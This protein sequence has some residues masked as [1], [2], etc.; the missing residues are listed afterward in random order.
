MCLTNDE[1]GCKIFLRYT[2]IVIF[3]SEYFILMAHLVVAYFA[4]LPVKN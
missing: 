1:I 3:V 2:D 4:M